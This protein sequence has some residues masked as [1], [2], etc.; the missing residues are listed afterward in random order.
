[1]VFN[2]I[3]ITGGSRNFC[4]F[5][6]FSKK[7]EKLFYLNDTLEPSLESSYLQESIPNI[8]KYLDTNEV[9]TNTFFS[10]MGIKSKEKCLG[11]VVPNGNVYTVSASCK[12]NS[13]GYDI[14][15]ILT[16]GITL[17]TLDSISEVTGGYIFSG[18]TSESG[19]IG[20]LDKN[21]NLKWQT[22]INFAEKQHAVY[23]VIEIDD[24][25]VFFDQTLKSLI[26]QF[27]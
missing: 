21:G 13:S 17:E 10:Q 2:C 6:F 12:N 3:N 19:V 24:G 15:Y 26:T 7:T 1:M 5:E 9:K 11:T 20:F 23:N 8:L 27:I 22:K 14:K 25:Y 18:T 4:L 16:K